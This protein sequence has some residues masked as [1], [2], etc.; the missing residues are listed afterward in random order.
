MCYEIP[1][2]GGVTVLPPDVVEWALKLDLEAAGLNFSPDTLLLYKFNI[3]ESE[4]L[5][6]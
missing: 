3:L 5:Y 2:A 6:T 1:G 4:G